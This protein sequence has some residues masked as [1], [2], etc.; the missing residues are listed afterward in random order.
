MSRAEWKSDFRGLSAP[1]DLLRYETRRSRLCPGLTAHA[2]SQ[3]TLPLEVGDYA[4]A[5]ELHQRLLQAEGNNAVAHYHCGGLPMAWRGSATE[6]IAEY[7]RGD[8]AGTQKMGSVSES[9][10]CL[11]AD[12]ATS[13]KSAIGR[14]RDCCIARSGTR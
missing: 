1:A 2:T 9:R 10:A 13:L 7:R 14:S 4:T 6:E 11:I 5:I 3:R 12:G 8:R